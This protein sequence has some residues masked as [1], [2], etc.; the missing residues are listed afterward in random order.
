MICLLFPMINGFA[1]VKIHQSAVYR[2]VSPCAFI[3][4]VS[5]STDGSIQSCAWECIHQNECQT[6][7]YFSDTNICSL[8]I[9]SCKDNG[10]QPSGN[11]PA[12][13]ICY[14]KNHG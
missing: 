1:I 13:V 5:I 12:S 4:N 8:F 6:A 7:V 14:P 11:T 3:R 2:P 10:I 9:E